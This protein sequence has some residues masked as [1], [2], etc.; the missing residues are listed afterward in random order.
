MQ[1]LP[2]IQLLES[3]HHFPGPYMFKVIGRAESGFVAL[4]VAAVRE[5]LAEGIDPP[6][7]VRSARGGRH[8]SITLEPTV[9][10]AMA[11]V[12]TTGGFGR[13]TWP[14]PQSWPMRMSPRPSV[15]TLAKV[16]LPKIRADAGLVESAVHGAEG[17][18][19]GLGGA[20]GGGGM[21]GGTTQ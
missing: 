3:T 20:G 1:N 8:L 2:A 18:G 12:A 21:L 6:F 5:E 11:G 15:E 14:M 16:N 7:K 4:V 13:C 17:I 19:A 10:S 9:Q